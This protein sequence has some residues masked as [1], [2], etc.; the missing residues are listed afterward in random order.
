M[1][2]V[3]ELVKAAG[4]RGWIVLI[5]EIELVANYSVLQRARSYAELIVGWAKRPMKSTRG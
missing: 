3:L 1:R 5:D 4:Y 2:F